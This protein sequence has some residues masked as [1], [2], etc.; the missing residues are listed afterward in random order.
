MAKT[1]NK[2]AF[3]PSYVDIMTTLFAITL[4]LF[5]VSF[6]RFRVKEAELRVL[7]DKYKEIVSIYSAVENIDPNYFAYDSIYSKFIFKIDVQ[8][9]D[10]G[11]DLN[12]EL[13]FDQI[14]NHQAADT[15]RK[16]VIKAGEIIKN[17]IVK[18]Q[19]NDSIKQD[20]KYLV[21]IEG[22]ASKD[23]YPDNYGLSYRRAL[24]LH[25]FWKN[26]PEA[27]DFT[28]M[29]KC[30]LVICGSGTGGV[31]RVQVDPNAPWPERERQE[32]LNQRFLIHIVPV[33]GKISIEDRELLKEVTSN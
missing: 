13:M 27:I 33:I 14:G 19:Q 2:G 15:I 22:Q 4:V 17:T 25:N 24:G 8:F 5:A 20:I 10:R 29:N 16:K 23:N 31:P 30:E 1:D 9:Q 18:L 21:V 12:T 32:K 3:W 26:S 7:A 11:Y 6:V 28:S